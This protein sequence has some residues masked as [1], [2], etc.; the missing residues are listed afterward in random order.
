MSKTKRMCRLCGKNPATVP[1][2]GQ[3]GSPRKAVCRPCHAIELADDLKIIL[4]LEGSKREPPTTTPE[5]SE[6]GHPQDG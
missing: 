1:D 6:V 2:R 5:A 4:N 3:M